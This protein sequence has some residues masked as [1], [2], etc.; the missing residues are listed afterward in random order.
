[1]FAASQGRPAARG[2]HTHIESAKFESTHIMQIMKFPHTSHA[3][4]PPGPFFW[5]GRRGICLMKLTRGK[6]V[7]R[8]IRTERVC[9]KLFVRHTDMGRSDT[10]HCN[11]A[12][13]VCQ[14]Q[15]VN[16]GRPGTMYGFNEQVVCTGVS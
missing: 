7:K 9:I 2:T 16:F 15:R 11:I 4:I 3:H 1:M 6:C 8:I 10:L 5:A 14:R 13:E 12:L